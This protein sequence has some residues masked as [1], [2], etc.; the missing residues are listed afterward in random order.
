[1]EF[2]ACRDWYLGSFPPGEVNRQ[3]AR[4]HDGLYRAYI[5]GESNTRAA[6]HQIVREWRT[7]VRERADWEKYRERL[8]KQVQDFKKIKSAFV[9]EKAA[10]EVEKKS[11]EWGREGLKSKLQAAEELLSKERAKWKKV[12]EKDN[13][14][15]YAARSKITDLEAQIATLK[16]KVEEVEADKGHVE[17]ASK[18]KD[19][20]AKDVE[21]AELKRRLFE[22][23]DKN[24]SLEIDLEAE[25]VK[26]DTAEEAKKKAEEA[27][28]IST[29]ALNVAQNNYAEAQ[30]IVDTL[31]SESEWMR[32]RGVDAIANS[33]LNATE[34]DGAVA[35]L[36]DA[37][38]AVG[39]RGVI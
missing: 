23:I 24:E 36:I 33:I 26:A 12:C 39:H 19:L 28:D 22:A 15:M 29:S 32:G 8:L 27:R 38:R 16:G 31:V 7:M 11:E 10:F 21:I 1:M 5:V 17:V 4:T 25:R 35:A 37:S 18:D 34:L 9:E 2:A 20:A 13:Q 14:R 6:N 30:S 3:R